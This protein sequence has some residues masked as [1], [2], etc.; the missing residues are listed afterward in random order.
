VI[1][2]KGKEI[3]NWKV[4]QICL[5]CLCGIIAGMV[6][7][8]LGLGG[9]F[10]LGPLFLELGIPPQVYSSQFLCIYTILKVCPIFFILAVLTCS[11]RIRCLCRSPCFIE[12][13]RVI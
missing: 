7:G 2:S 1:G 13:Y 10:I 4:H 5:Y 3:T 12:F 11:C 9:G 6:G 8:L